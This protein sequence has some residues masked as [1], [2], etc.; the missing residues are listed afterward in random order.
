M[1][2]YIKRNRTQY[3]IV[4]IFCILKGKKT[5]ANNNNNKLKLHLLQKQS[6]FYFSFIFSVFQREWHSCLCVC[7]CVCVCVLYVPSG[8]QKISTEVK[9]S[10]RIFTFVSKCIDQKQRISHNPLLSQ[11]L[12]E[13]NVLPYQYSVCLRI[14]LWKTD[15]SLSLTKPFLP[16][17]NEGIYNDLLFFKFNRPLIVLQSENLRGF[18][19]L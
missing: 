7:V 14:Y 17:Q 8:I 5:N 16:F 13:T 15:T 1:H 3:S 9:D 10:R 18:Q 4:K 11:H 12:K 2:Y 19:S 6:I